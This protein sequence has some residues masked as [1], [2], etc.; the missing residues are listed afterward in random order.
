MNSE[1]KEWLKSIALAVVIALVIRIFF[2]ETFLVEGISMYPTLRH[3][4]RL[5]VN[6]ISYNFQKPQHGDIIVF[7]Y[8]SRR[9]FIKRAIAFGSDKVEIWEN[10]LYVNG[11]RQVEPYIRSQEMH[12]FGPVIV[13][14]GHVFVLGDNRNNSMDS[15][16]PAVGAISMERVKG[17]AMFVFWPFSRVGMVNNTSKD[18]HLTR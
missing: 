2:F 17:E 12:D 9:D 14:D 10:Y 18:I 7:N 13:P 11:K 1:L 15:R 16:D 6:K 5:V 3:H 4:E 8:A